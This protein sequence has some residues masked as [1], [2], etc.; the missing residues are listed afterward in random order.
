MGSDGGHHANAAARRHVRSPMH[1]LREWLQRLAGSLH[2]SRT[3]RDLAEELE[4]HIELAKEDA[5]RH[6]H[7]GFDARRAANI[8]WGG[9][10]QAMDALRDQRGAPWLTA[11]GSDF[12]FGWRQ[13]NKH[14]TVSAAAILSLGLA[15]GA[16]TAAFRLVDGVLLRK[17][18]VSNPDSL[19]YVAFTSSDSQNRSEERDDFDY[20]TYQRYLTAIGNR[21]ELMVVGTTAQQNNV[22]INDGDEPERVF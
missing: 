9:A 2:R 6:G 22:T 18:P 3:D 12:V 1:L 20:P 16:T 5:E 4:L 21:A 15:I 19:S 8:Q 10:A 14:R 13:L 7:S 11:L 17:L